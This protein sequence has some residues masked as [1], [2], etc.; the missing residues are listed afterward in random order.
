MNEKRQE[1]AEKF[2]QIAVERH[3]KENP[4]CGLCMRDRQYVEAVHAQV[5]PGEGKDLIS[6]CSKHRIVT[7]P[8][9]GSP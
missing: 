6:V 7:S 2:S 1:R 8:A 3:L 5:I 9:R 4:Y